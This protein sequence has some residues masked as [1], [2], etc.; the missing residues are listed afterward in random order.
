MDGYEDQF[1]KECYELAGMYNKDI[2]NIEMRDSCGTKVLQI[3]DYITGTLGAH[4]E[5]EKDVENPC[6]KRFTIIRSKVKEIV[7][8]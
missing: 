6:H 8:R 3:H 7:K 1:V 2:E 5:N 4:I